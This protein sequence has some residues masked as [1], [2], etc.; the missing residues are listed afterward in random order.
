VFTGAV[1]LRKG[2]FPDSAIGLEQMRFWFVHLGLDLYDSTAA[3]LEWFWPRISSGGILL[4]HDY[5]LIDGVVQAFHEF[6]DGRPEPFI[7]A[8]WKSVHGRE[9]LRNSARQRGRRPD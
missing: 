1:A 4:S 3:A 9:V 7:P 5:P 2:L 8:L 6:F